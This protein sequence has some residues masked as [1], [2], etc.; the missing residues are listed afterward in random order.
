MDAT[1]RAEACRMGRRQRMGG[2]LAF[3]IKT[4]F[5]TKR[6]SGSDKN[7]DNQEPLINRHGQ[8]IRKQ[9]HISACHAIF[10]PKKPNNYKG[11]FVFSMV[12]FLLLHHENTVIRC[13]QYRARTDLI[14][15]LQEELFLS[16][17]KI[18]LSYRKIT[19]KVRTGSKHIHLSAQPGLIFLHI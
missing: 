6:N 2:D 12:C 3:T 14:N 16:C 18:P 4:T 15:S 7:N 9:N 19:F 11:V 10:P 17:Q 5:K 1:S 13:S 8:N